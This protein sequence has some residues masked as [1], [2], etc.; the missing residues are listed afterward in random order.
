MRCE[1][2]LRALRRRGGTRSTPFTDPKATAG[3]PAVD[4]G[5]TPLTARTG[6]DQ[7]RRAE[8]GHRGDGRLFVLTVR[9]E[10]PLRY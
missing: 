4:Y 6:L 2:R 5:D 9:A 8:I 10:V 7:H 3:R 1:F